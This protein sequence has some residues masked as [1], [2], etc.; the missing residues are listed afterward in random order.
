MPGRDRGLPGWRL[1]PA[2]QALHTGGVIAYPTEAVWGLGCDP[3]DWRAFQRL[4]ELKQRPL[5]K[6][7]ILVA[8]NEA[9]LGSLLDNLADEQLATL[10]QGME[11]PTTWLMPS[12]SSIPSWIR[13]RHDSVAVRISAHPCIKSLCEAFGGMIVSTSANRA[14]LPAAR[15]HLRARCL[16]GDSVDAYVSGAVGGELSPS[17]IVDLATGQVLR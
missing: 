5:D 7:V 2:L 13:G 15:S 1:W 3:Y 16:F 8:A 11:K 14:G 6:G 17:R 9:Q 12:D 4:L 10:R